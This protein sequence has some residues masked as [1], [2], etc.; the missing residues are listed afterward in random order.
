MENT[1]EELTIEELREKI[2]REQAV[3]NEIKSQSKVNEN[4]LKQQADFL[5]KEQSDL[6]QGLQ[7]RMEL[8]S[9]LKKDILRM[10]YSESL[11]VDSAEYQSKETVISVPSSDPTPSSFLTQAPKSVIPKSSATK[12]PKQ[13][14]PKTNSKIPSKPSGIKPTQRVTIV[15]PKAPS[16]VKKPDSTKNF[17]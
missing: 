2:K 11:R 14:P 13:P 12:E 10:A 7:A 3:L 4:N 1:N 6:I 8:V 9:M 17:Q 16:P 15:V 5:K